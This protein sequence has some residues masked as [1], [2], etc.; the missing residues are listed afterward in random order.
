MK[1]IAVS[2]GRLRGASVF[3]VDGKGF[4]TGNWLHP[5]AFQVV[6]AAVEHFRAFAA[7]SSKYPAIASC[8]SSSGPRPLCAARSLS[9]FSTSRG[10][11]Y[12][13]GSQSTGP[14]RP[15]QVALFLFTQS[16][17]TLPPVVSQ[18]RTKR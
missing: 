8:T 13:H 7:S 5:A 14:P 11:L 15:R 18:D 10:E 3:A 4:V 12:F 9:F 17:Y 1:L 16:L 2:C 6:I